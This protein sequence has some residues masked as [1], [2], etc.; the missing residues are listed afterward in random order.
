MWWL[1][2]LDPITGV[3][4]ILGCQEQ[5]LCRPPEPGFE[6]GGRVSRIAGHV[7]VF[8]LLL[9]RG[10]EL[11]S[12][13][14]GWLF[15]LQ[16]PVLR[17]KMVVCWCHGSWWSA[18]W[19]GLYPPVLLRKMAFL[20]IIDRSFDFSV[21]QMWWGL[22][23]FHSFFCKLICYFISP[24]ADVCWYPL[25]NNTGSL[26]KGANVLYELLLRCVKF[27]RHEGLQSWQ[28]VC[29][30]DYFPGLLLTRNDGSCGIQQC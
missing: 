1:H 29:E 16:W 9:H 26:S 8:G 4:H 24:N 19:F 10:F 12:L 27:I 28:W 13:H 2:W 5:I 11:R 23:L 21:A 14:L 18:S 6:V 3:C 30:E 15:S 17:W 25:K 7:L 20:F 22:L